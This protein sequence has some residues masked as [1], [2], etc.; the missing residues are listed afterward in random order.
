MA[1]AQ[2]FGIDPKSMES[3]AQEIKQVHDHGVQIGIIIGGGNIFR[4]LK[5]ESL[6]M[7]RITGDYMGML[8][9]VINSI[10]LQDVLES[11]GVPTR[12][13][14]AINIDQMVEPFIR[15]R[16]LRHLEKGRIVIFS[17]GTGSPNFTTD[18][19]ASLRAIEME[20]DVIL[21]G[22]DVKGVYDSDPR[23]NSNAFMYDEL[24]Y[25]DVVKKGL[26]VMD[27]TAITLSMDN[28]L[29]IIIF[30]FSVY[31]NLLKIVKGEK[32]GTIVRD[33]NHD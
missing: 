10:A 12:V 8:A 16:A 32:I 21:K 14:S 5:V 1:G 33:N 9:T 29:P 2:K 6:G 28:Q 30:N 22:T 18:T 27:P 20:A 19:A 7:Q 13:C 31:G 23:K 24:T 25:L 4:G 26:R 3:A 15:R 17:A 11:K